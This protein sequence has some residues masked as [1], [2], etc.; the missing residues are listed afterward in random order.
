MGKISKTLK[1]VYV[2]ISVPAVLVVS[3]VVASGWSLRNA[4]R[5][6][7]AACALFDP[8]M[9]ALKFAEALKKANYK[10]VRADASSVE[11]VFRSNIA[12]E[13]FE[14]VV[15]RDENGKYFA[16]VVQVN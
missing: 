13:R 10:S 1:I 8:A 14:C 3:Y 16:D 15:K 2:A 7:T 6:A 12:A 4:E 5:D 11:V 9:N